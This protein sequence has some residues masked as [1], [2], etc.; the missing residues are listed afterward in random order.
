MT[1]EPQPPLGLRIRWALWGIPQRYETFPEWIARRD[2]NKRRFVAAVL[3]VSIAITIGAWV[4]LV[5]A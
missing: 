4:S 1:T 2:R 5:L 3:A